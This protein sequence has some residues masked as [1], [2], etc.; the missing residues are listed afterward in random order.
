MSFKYNKI[1]IELEDQKRSSHVWS[2]DSGDLVIV[3]IDDEYN[4][5]KRPSSSVPPDAKALPLL[6]EMAHNISE[7]RAI[8]FF[9]L[10]QDEKGANKVLDH[11]QKWL[12]DLDFDESVKV[13]FLIDI[14]GL[15]ETEVASPHTVGKLTELSYSRD[16]IAH[17]TRAGGN[18]V[19]HTVED[20]VK[21]TE[22][23]DMEFQKRFS[24]KFESFLGIDYYHTDKNINA[25]IQFYAKAWK[26]SWQPKGWAHDYLEGRNRYS[27]HLQALAEWLGDSVSIDDLVSN[28]TD[29]TESAKSL[30]IWHE[31]NLWEMENPP[32]K[33]RDRR[34]IKGKVLNA[35]LR[36]LGIPLSDTNPIPDEGL[37]T[38]PCVPCFPLFVSLR[39]FLWRCEE[40]EEE[41]S[42]SELC[43]FQ[44][45]E[46]P[47]VNVFRLVLPLRDPLMLAKKFFGIEEERAGAFTNSLRDLT[48]CRTDGL[49]GHGDYMPLFTNG[50]ESPV[51]AVEIAPK[52]IN[53]I[54]SVR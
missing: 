32:W 2:R 48:Y 13:R 37:I 22:V 12:E 31:A 29:Q 1:E 17:F 46:T 33:A 28:E 50:T 3:V 54:W 7:T 44:S 40:E 25:A 15:G 14:I 52:Q 8:G 5:A 16:Q 49:E 38:M 9:P 4:T 21:G 51:V 39:G 6:R 18:E 36:K 23:L 10:A 43:F 42:V 34:R 47:Q 53:L 24:P 45:G 11:I 20:F 26:S 41:I 35:V 27:P 19:R 30:M